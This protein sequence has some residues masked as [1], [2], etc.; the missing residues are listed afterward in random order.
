MSEKLAAILRKHCIDEKPKEKVQ[1]IVSNYDLPS[2]LSKLVPTKVN[3]EIWRTC[4]AETKKSRLK[5]ANDSKE[6]GGKSC[7]TKSAFL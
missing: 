4:S 1:P 3:H 7:T 5:N 6:P 2:N